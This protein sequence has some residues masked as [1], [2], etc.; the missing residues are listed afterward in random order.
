[1]WLT[2]MEGAPWD[3]SCDYPVF[4]LEVQLSRAILLM[5]IRNYNMRNYNDNKIIFKFE[6]AYRISS[7]SHKGACLS[8]G[9]R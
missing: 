2:E 9:Q 4:V 1:M 6:S 8:Q 3:Q 7:E 5:G